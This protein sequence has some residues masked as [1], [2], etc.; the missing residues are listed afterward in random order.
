MAKADVGLYGS[1]TLRT[2]WNKQGNMDLWSGFYERIGN[3]REIRYFDIGSKLTGLVSAQWPPHA[4][5]SASQLMSLQT[6]NH[7]LKGFIREYNGERHQH[8][9]RLLRMTSTKQWKLCVIAAWTLC[10]LQILILQRVDERVKGHGEDTDLLC[11]LVRSD[12]MK[13]TWD[14]RRHLAQIFTQTVIGPVFFEIIQRKG[15]EGLWRQLQ[16]AVW[17]DWRGPDPPSGDTTHKMDPASYWEGVCRNKRMLISPKRLSMS[18]RRR[19]QRRPAPSRHFH[20][21]IAPTGWS[22]EWR[23][24]TPSRFWFYAGGKSQPDNPG[25]AHNADCKISYGVWMRRWISGIA[26]WWW[27]A[28]VH[29]PR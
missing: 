4:A 26:I 12:L 7:K 6:I 19:G 9:V 28:T 23:R 5:K 21:Q 20:H 18:R 14:Q 17:I 11:E 8:M 29:S 13:C 27:W 3:F 2:T 24:L 25:R 1:T 15:N 22:S 16:G 10:Q